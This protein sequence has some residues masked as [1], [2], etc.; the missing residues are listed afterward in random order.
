V[1]EPDE[2]TPSWHIEVPSPQDWDEIFRLDMRAFHRDPNDEASAAERGIFEFDRALVARRA[3]EIVGTAALLTRPLAVP[4]AVLPAAHVSFVA[5]APGA[6]RQGILT[7]FMDR[8]F[9]DAR[10]AG[11]AIAVLWASEGRIYQRFGYGLAST[12]LS[13]SFERH[14]VQLTVPAD[15]RGLRETTPAQVRD[16]LVKLYDETY[17]QRPG[18]SGREERHWDY[19]LADVPAWRQGATALRAV[20][21][22]DTGGATDGYALWRTESRWT[23]VGPS[24]TV[25]VVELVARTPE[26]YT[27]LWSFL[28]NIDLTRTVRMWLAGAD[29]PLFRA[30]S[31]PRQLNARLSDGLWLRILDVPAALQARRYATAIDL[32]IEV[33]DDRIP[34]NNGRWRLTGSPDHARCVSTVDEPDLSC[35][36]RA[37]GATYLGGSSLD[38]LAATGQVVEHRPGALVRAGLALRWHVAATSPEIF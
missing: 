21:H 33:R 30:V 4:G 28:M 24:G 14:E 8:Q 1:T 20:L 2:P 11:E 9:S 18:W 17:R 34:S 31:D 6:R 27:A 35:D 12:V 3:G 15:V 22:R 38:A 7:A 16:E 13:L 5:V 29:E 26:A 23:E 19:R 10:A 37:L 25:H 36:I 32:V